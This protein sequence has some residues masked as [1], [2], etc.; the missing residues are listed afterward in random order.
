MNT[1]ES[2]MSL[3]DVRGNDT[4]DKSDNDVTLLPPPRFSHVVYTFGKVIHFFG[5]Y[6]RYF[7]TVFT[8]EFLPLSQLRNIS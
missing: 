1:W 6:C 4:I 5:P 2:D 8:F 3:F 7:N